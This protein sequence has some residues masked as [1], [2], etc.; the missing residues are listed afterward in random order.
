MHAGE[1]TIKVRGIVRVYAVVPG[2]EQRLGLGVPLV[3]RALRQAVAER[4]AVLVHE[5]SNLIVNYGLQALAVFIG[6]LAGTPSVGGSPPASMSAITV[7]TMQIGNASSPPTPVG[8]DTT[9][10]GSLVYTPPLTVTYPTAYSTMF[11]GV[12]PIGECNEDLLTEEAL[13]LQN[14]IVFAK[15]LINWPKTSASAVQ[16]DHTIAFSLA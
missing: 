2:V 6:N 10:V 13:L 1:A 7:A 14:A 11:S 9:G 3:G 16:I 12:I 5:D 4:S 8:T 15:A